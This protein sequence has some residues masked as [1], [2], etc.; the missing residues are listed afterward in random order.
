MRPRR[1]AV[2]R[3]RSLII[4]SVARRGVARLSAVRP[5]TQPCSFRFAIASWRY[6]LEH[7]AHTSGHAAPETVKRCGAGSRLRRRTSI[8]V[9]LLGLWCYAAFAFSDDRLSTW[10]SFGDTAPYLSHVGAQFRVHLLVYS[11]IV[12]A[13]FL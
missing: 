5:T 11:Q 9:G 1:F 7:I 12:G 3:S 13:G 2:R 4:G 10:L 6:S 8:S